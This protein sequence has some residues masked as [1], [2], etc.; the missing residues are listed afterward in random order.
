MLMNLDQQSTPQHDQVAIA[1]LIGFQLLIPTTTRIVPKAISS[2][3]VNIPERQYASRGWIV[4]GGREIAALH[5]FTFDANFADGTPFDLSQRLGPG[6]PISF[7]SRSVRSLPGS[8]L[9]QATFSYRFPDASM[10]FHSVFHGLKSRFV[11]I[12]PWTK[13]TSLADMVACMLT[14]EKQFIETNYA[15]LQ[16]IPFYQEQFNL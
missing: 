5:G 12:Y 10:P 4:A 13:G 7:E 6:V 14:D 16:A 2:A 3:W 11:R 8:L 9:S 15:R 1:D